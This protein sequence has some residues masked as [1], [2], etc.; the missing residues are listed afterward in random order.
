VAKKQQ[1][2]RVFRVPCTSEL[3]RIMDEHARQRGLTMS[4]WVRELVVS[5][6]RAEGIEAPSL[7]RDYAS[8]ARS[9]M[10]H[11]EDRIAA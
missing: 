5:A 10:I 4:A 9:R 8:P 6:L 3:A 7:P 1:F 2:D 11:R